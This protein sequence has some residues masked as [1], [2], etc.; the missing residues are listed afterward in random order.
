MKSAHPSP[1]A[2]GLMT[3]GRSVTQDRTLIVLKS[4]LTDREGDSTTGIMYNWHWSSLKRFKPSVVIPQF[5]KWR[6]E[7]D[8]VEMCR[9][10]I[11]SYMVMSGS[12]ST[13]PQVV[14]KWQLWV[15]INFAFVSFRLGA[16]I[17]FAITLTHK[18]TA[19]QSS[20]VIV[21]Q[22]TTRNFILFNLYLIRQDRFL[23]QIK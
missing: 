7:R 12:L 17:S 14:L 16:A 20:S 21:N 9:T 18:N 8:G 23:L 2:D 13:Q 1:L 6:Q 3:M 10:G 22:N 5:V 19:H 4:F 11:C 15:P